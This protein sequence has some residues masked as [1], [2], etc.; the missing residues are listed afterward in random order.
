[1]QNDSTEPACL[2]CGAPLQYHECAREMTCAICGKICL[3]NAECIHGHFVCDDCHSTPAA[4]VIRSIALAASE[5]DPFV[6]TPHLGRSL[7]SCSV[8]ECRR[9]T[10]SSHSSRGDASP[11]CDGS[12]WILRACRDLRG[13]NQCRDVLLHCNENKSP[14]QRNLERRTA[15]NCSMSYCNWQ[16]RRTALL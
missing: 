16:S 4:V 13:C 10:G 2:I 15:T 9:R 6:R 14:E 5:K 12:G 8:P 11:R 7:T 1:M 3:S